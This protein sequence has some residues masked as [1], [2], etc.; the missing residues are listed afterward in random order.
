M[1]L[2]VENVLMFALVLFALYYFV[3]DYEEGYSLSKGKCCFRD[4]ECESGDCSPFDTRM[5]NGVCSRFG[6]LD[7]I[8]G[9][10]RTWG[11]CQ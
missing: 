4:N 10:A 2:S 11:A 8:G 7:P 6:P 3:S 1:N 9:N 5:F